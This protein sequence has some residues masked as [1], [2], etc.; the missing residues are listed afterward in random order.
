MISDQSLFI[1]FQSFL[2]SLFCHFYS[3]LNT[4]CLPLTL[5]STLNNVYFWVIT[6]FSMDG[7]II[8]FEMPFSSWH[9]FLLCFLLLKLSSSQI[10]ILPFFDQHIISVILKM[11]LI[12][13]HYWVHPVQQLFLK[14]EG[15][16]QEQ[17]IKIQNA[18]FNLNCR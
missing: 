18:H 15:G 6:T 17:Q 7:S 11:P 5:N 3:L 14:T 10:E 9:F 1:V 8:R 13:S 4:T 2:S 16:C 12:C